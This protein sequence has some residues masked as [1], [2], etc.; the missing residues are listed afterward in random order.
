MGRCYNISVKTYIVSGQHLLTKTCNGFVAINIGDTIV[1][2]KQVQLKPPP[3]PA[4]SGESTGV[5]GNADEIFTGDNG[6]ISIL[7]VGPPGVN[8]K[9]Q[10]VEKYYTD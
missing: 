7:F 8:P 1:Q 3:A 10:I 6:V 9:V 5:Q 2:V 4:L